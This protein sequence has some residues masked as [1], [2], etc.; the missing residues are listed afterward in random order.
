MRPITFL[1]LFLIRVSQFQLYSQVA[2]SAISLEVVS[3]HQARIE[4]QPK[5][6]Y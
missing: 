3:N 4:A 2:P 1:F 6:T 5:F